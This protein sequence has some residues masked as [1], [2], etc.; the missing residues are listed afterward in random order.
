MKC[1]L[2]IVTVGVIT[3]TK[4]C[5]AVKP[6]ANDIDGAANTGISKD[7]TSQHLSLLLNATLSLQEQE[8]AVPCYCR[9]Q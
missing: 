3:A 2:F 7:R 8:L 1:L 6:V 9:L 5:S 4:H